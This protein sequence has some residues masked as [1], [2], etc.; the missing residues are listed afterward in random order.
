M[1]RRKAQVSMEYLLIV[2]FAFLMLV[3]LIIIYYTSQQ[4]LNDKI[5]ISQADRIAL[6]IVDTADEV[7]YQGPPTKKTFKV[8]MPDDVS[9]INIQ[10]KY[11]QINLK[12]QPGTPRYSV[13]NLSGNLSAY[14]GLHIIKVTA[15]DGKVEITDED[16]G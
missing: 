15:L 6:E 8:Y 9:A 4:D 3:P 7:F 10:D 2:G 1:W 11:V 5:T 16:M 13:A 12:T 14:G